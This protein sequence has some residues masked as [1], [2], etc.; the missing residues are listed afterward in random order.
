MLDALGIMLSR[1][2][3]RSTKGTGRFFTDSDIR[4]GASE[5][6]NSIDIE[7][8]QTLFSGQVAKTKRG[9]KKQTTNDYQFDQ[10]I[11]NENRAVKIY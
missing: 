7:Y 4:K 6:A 3:I 2:R 9:K 1:A 5:T 10:K 11:W 8:N